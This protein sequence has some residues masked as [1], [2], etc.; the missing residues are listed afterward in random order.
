[1]CG[2]SAGATLAEEKC[3]PIYDRP[4]DRPIISSSR[5][6][7]RTAVMSGP[8]GTQRRV[9]HVVSSGLCSREER[10]LSRNSYNSDGI[11][12][13]AFFVRQYYTAGR[14]AAGRGGAGGMAR[15]RGTALRVRRVG[16]HR[17]AVAVGRGSHVGLSVV[18]P[19][20]WASHR[21]YRPVISSL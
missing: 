14:R 18:S 6:R 8:D 10:V 16:R 15:G 1:M 3:A 13:S 19:S 11:G 21:S 7:F 5:R 17:V 9:R 12:L 20:V 2:A 4:P